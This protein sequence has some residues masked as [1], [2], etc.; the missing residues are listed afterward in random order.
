MDTSLECKYEPGVHKIPDEEYFKI[1]YMSFSFLSEFKRCG[2]NIYKA[3]QSRDNI[4]EATRKAF[5]IGGAVHMLTL[6][7][8]IFYD[9]YVVGPE[10]DKRTK[11]G[12][13]EHEAFLADV[14]GRKI[15]PYTDWDT[16]QG[17]S[18]TCKHHKSG[19]PMI[20]TT[21][22]EV[23]YIWE[24]ETTGMMMKAKAD[25]VGDGFIMDLKT[26]KDADLNTFAKSIANF[27][28]HMQAAIYLDG[29]HACTGEGIEDYRILAAEKVGTFEVGLYKLPKKLIADGHL[30][31][32]EYLALYKALSKKPKSGRVVWSNGGPV[33]I[34]RRPGYNNDEMVEIDIP[35]W[36]YEPASKSPKIRYSYNKQKGGK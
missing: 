4:T 8:E 29:H 31:F 18:F 1:P 20:G 11:K 19:G 24:E 10:A 21:R 6:E 13:E 7:P 25:M 27:R 15:I 3:Q 30:K 22:K 14:G 17:I 33:E 34:I 5:I 36:G 35:A 23:V 28:Y 16:I 12:R 32:V 26:T 2:F 9:N